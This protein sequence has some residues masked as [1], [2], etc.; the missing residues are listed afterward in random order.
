M[1]AHQPYVELMVENQLLIRKKD[2]PLGKVMTYLPLL[3][4]LKQWKVLKSLDLYGASRAGPPV[5]FAP[6]LTE[7]V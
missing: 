6:N 3:E 7:R 2:F 1:E 4:M 5:R